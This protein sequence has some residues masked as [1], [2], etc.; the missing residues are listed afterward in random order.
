MRADQGN[1]LFGFKCSAVTSQR[2]DPVYDGKQK[3]GQVT[4]AAWSPQLECG[5]GYI[6]FNQAQQWIGRK[7]GL[8]EDTHEQH[9]CEII[10]LPFF[11]S[12]KQ[13]PRGGRTIDRG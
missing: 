6:R 11:D 5:I 13:I 4:A 12:E 10:K 8:G 7:L 3:V 1:L 9:E 2:G